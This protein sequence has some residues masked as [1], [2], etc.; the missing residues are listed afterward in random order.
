MRRVESIVAAYAPRISS[1]LATAGRSRL[2]ERDAIL[3]T[4]ADQLQEPERAP[5]GS[6][7]SF[8]E[9]RVRGPI[10]GL[11]LLPFYP[12][13]SDD[14][15]AVMDYHRVDPAFGDWEDIARLGRSFDLMFD[16]VFNHL[17]AQGRWFLRFLQDASEY[18]N[19]F[20]TV[21]DDPDLSQVIRPRTHPLLTEFASARGPLRVWTT[22]SADQVDLDFSNPEVLLAII[23]A[24]LFYVSQGA[25]F[26]R[27][28]AIAFLWKQIGTP[29]LHLPQ[30]HRV[31]QALR[32]V[33]DGVAPKVM[34]ITE[35]NVPHADNISYF[36]NGENEAQLVYNFALPPLVLHS[37]AVG[38]A[39]QLSRWA[40]SLR[41]PSETSTFLNFLASHD[42]IGL[43]PARGILA[44][45]EIQ[46]LV[47]R[48]LAHGGF[49]SAKALPDGSQA[50]YELNINYF[51]ALS[52]PTGDET[53]EAQV[54][55]FI[56][57]HAIMFS[58]PGVPAVYFHSLVGSRGDRAGALATGI[59]RRI[60]REKMLRTK[61]ESELTD[62][63]SLRQR[64]FN[65]M[66]GLLEA[67][68]AHKAFDPRAGA[69]VLSVD[70]RLFVIRRIRR[71]GAPLHCVHNVSGDVVELPL[72]A[73][74][75]DFQRGCRTVWPKEP[76]EIAPSRQVVRLPPFSVWWA[77]AP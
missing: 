29:C 24:L 51:D 35:T 31:V 59:R 74:T 34:L 6:L 9:E 14:G 49:V 55:R 64:V 12:S 38:R 46:S 4:Y 43:N 60:N 3:I 23:E 2:T 76:P 20:L 48:T 45:A 61:L 10:T 30:T 16:A 52:N 56:C 75:N 69:E 25:R 19:F 72:A 15:F 26:V 39:E 27:L 42:G 65:Q 68:G 71:D 77:E 63:G 50:P 44:D 57:A 54:A 70:Q 40:R 32:T 1:P 66:T 28:D 17:S 41:S 7:A 62:P 5:L 8:L 18:R 22:F 33:L 21:E 11:H 58:M 36:G 53:V 73:V 13:S 37:F 67:R 47:D